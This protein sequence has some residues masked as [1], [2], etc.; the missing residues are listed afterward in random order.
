MTEIVA[1]LVDETSLPELATM[2]N[3]YH[4]EAESSAQSAVQAAWFAGKALLAA[5][6]LCSHGQ[7]LP[8]LKANFHSTQQTAHKYMTLAS[9]YNHGCNFDP[10][11]SIR[12]A[13]AAIQK[14]S[15][16]AHVGNNSGDNEWYTPPAYISAAIEVM[17]G[18]DLDPASNQVAND[19]VGAAEFYTAQDNGLEQDWRGRVWMNPPYAQPLIDQFCTKLAA[20]HRC[21]NVEQ[22]CV[23]V[24]N[25]TETAW[26]QTLAEEA[27]AICF[28]RGR[29]KFWHPDKTSA[30]LQG[31]AVLYLGPKVDDFQ[32]AFEAFGFV[33]RKG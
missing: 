16:G 7:W 19:H 23:L 11:L 26:F 10:E 18:I 33:V 5:K 12:G 1:E 31:Q 8:W 3:R 20:E 9:N 22:A 14:E 17:G 24:N 13:L 21:G 29:I 30:P 2:A 32:M 4:E 25:A 28:P 15:N 6:N 27:S